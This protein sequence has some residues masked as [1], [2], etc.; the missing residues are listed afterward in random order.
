MV[1]SMRS[2]DMGIAGSQSIGIYTPTIRRKAYD[3]NA[4]MCKNVG[5]ESRQLKSGNKF[6][7][8]CRSHHV[9]L[10]ADKI[11]YLYTFS[12]LL[13]AGAFFSATAFI[14]SYGKEGQFSH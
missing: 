11:F 4:N 7:R 2:L 3:D 6:V 1:S 9:T 5:V 14:I 12:W 13:F 8:F 10:F